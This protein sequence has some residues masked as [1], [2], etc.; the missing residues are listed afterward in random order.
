MPHDPEYEN[1]VDALSYGM[2][3]A[4]NTKSQEA[5]PQPQAPNSQPPVR[6]AKQG[7]KGRPEGMNLLPGL[8]QETAKIL[9]EF[10]ESNAAMAERRNR[11]P[12]IHLDPGSQALWLQITRVVLEMH[13]SVLLT[14]VHRFLNKSNGDM[15]AAFARALRRYAKEILNTQINP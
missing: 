13:T 8:C 9:Y 5:N 14:D 6:Q 12:W 4:K 3:E 2:G 11:R 7:Q 1:L 10:W 15:G